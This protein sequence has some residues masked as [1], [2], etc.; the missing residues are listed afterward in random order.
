MGHGSSLAKV[1]NKFALYERAAN[2]MRSKVDVVTTIR[3]APLTQAVHDNQFIYA[4]PS[5]Y[6]KIIDLYPT[7]SCTPHDLAKRTS[8][9]TASLLKQ[10]KDKQ[11]AIEARDGARVLLIDWSGKTP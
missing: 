3:T 2:N 5:D 8:G 4:V 10:I 1:R 6:G 11:I 9:V 7:G